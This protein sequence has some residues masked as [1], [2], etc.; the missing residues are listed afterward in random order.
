MV[1]SNKQMTRD[2]KGFTIVE[3]LIVI[4]V[5]AILAAITIVAYN[6]I[7][8]RARDARRASDI[9]QIKKALLAYDARH[10][11]VVRP[12]VTG[13]TKPVGEPGMGGWDVSSSA[14][15][16]A[17][18]RNSNG[19]IPVDP[20]NESSNT[21]GPTSGDNRLYYYYCYDMGHASAYSDSAAVH[22][23]YRLDS[24][25]TKLDKFRVNSCLT[26]IPSE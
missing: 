12:A 17:F 16:L 21:T 7:Q 24:G 8:Q 10:G 11:G 20:V 2:K 26:A 19:N 22:L 13:Y 9:S 3:L 18:L 15:W 1:V 14:S 23:N 5:I 4:V 6:G 25:A